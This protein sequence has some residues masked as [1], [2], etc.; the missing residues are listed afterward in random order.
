MQ[1]FYFYNKN[2]RYTYIE[3]NNKDMKVTRIPY[4]RYFKNSILYPLAAAASVT[5]T[6]AA[7]PIIVIFPPRSPER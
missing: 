4:L 3:L 2:L 7:A 6:F 5:I 1:G